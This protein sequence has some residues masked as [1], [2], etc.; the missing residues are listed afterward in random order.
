M[1]LS[2]KENL[3][4]THDDCHTP[5]FTTPPFKLVPDLSSLVHLKVSQ[6]PPDLHIHTWRMMKV[7]DQVF[8]G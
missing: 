7:P 8:G 2:Q 6:E 1:D 5:I 3:K 4:N